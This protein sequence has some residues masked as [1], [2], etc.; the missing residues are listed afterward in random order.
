MADQIRKEDD[1]KVGKGG[2]SHDNRI[3]YGLLMGAGVNVAGLTPSQAWEMVSQL[4][5]MESKDWKRTDK[6]KEDIKNKNEALKSKGEDI[7]SITNKAKGYAIDVSFVGVS[8][9][10]ALNEAVETINEISREFGLSKLHTEK[11]KNLANG[12]M[13]SANG[14]TV[15]IGNR[16]IRNPNAAY[17]LCVENYKDYKQ[18][19]LARYEILYNSINGFEKE[20]YKQALD[21]AREEVKYSR[22]N[23]V[24]KGKEV[25]SIITHEMGHVIAGQKGFLGIER[26]GAINSTQKALLDCYKD[27]KKNGDIYKISAYA[28]SSPDEFFS[29]C[30]TV[31]KMGKEKLPD[32]IE[33]V[34]KEI[35]K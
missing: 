21:R 18:N 7:K 16:I 24:Y 15:N 34:I 10:A 22:H 20:K 26:Y 23:I 19:Q 35:L 13:A 2:G 5:L 27:S 14:D 32:N 28:A 25:K 8:N 3:A 33:K 12:V 1:E 29:E 6:D 11:T 30:F 9:L 4:N 17:R 31:Y